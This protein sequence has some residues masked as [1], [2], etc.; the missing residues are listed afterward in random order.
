MTKEA[1][2]YDR[3]K[4]VSSIG[5][6]TKTEQLCINECNQNIAPYIKVNLKCIKDLNVRLDTIK[7]IPKTQA[8]Q[9]LIQQQQHFFLYLFYRVKK[10]KAK[11]NQKYY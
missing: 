9:S 11:I 10:T 8:K 3:E 5:S 7:I 4:T 1:R 6:Y 2:L